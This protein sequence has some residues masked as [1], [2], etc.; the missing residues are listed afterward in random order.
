MSSLAAGWAANWS[1]FRRL[2]QALASHRRLIYWLGA[3][4]AAAAGRLVER[5]LGG[6]CGYIALGFLLGFM[7]VVFTFMGLAVEVRHVTLS[8]ASLALCAAQAFGAGGPAP[9]GALAWGLAGI[10]GIGVANFGVSFLLALLTAI[11]ARDVDRQGREG[12]RRML[13]AAFR[14][15]PWRFLGPPRDHTTGR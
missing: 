1:A 4:R 10:A 8:A 6:V 2:P 14:E 9:R 5:H 13:W 15:N 7:P 11:D 12:L 3:E